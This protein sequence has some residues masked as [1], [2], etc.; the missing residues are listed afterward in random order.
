MKTNRLHC[1]V[2]HNTVHKLLFDNTLH[3]L[4]AFLQKQWEYFS[5]TSGE[6]DSSDEEHSLIRIS[7]N[8][9]FSMEPTMGDIHGNR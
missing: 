4:A 5:H 3:K 1:I 9:Y 7:M 2:F 6:S 8:Q